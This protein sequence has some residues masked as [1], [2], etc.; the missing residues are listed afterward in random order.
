MPLGL[1]HLCHVLLVDIG[2]CDEF[3][4]DGIENRAAFRTHCMHIPAE[5]VPAPAE[6]VLAA[7]SAAVQLAVA[8]A[9]PSPPAASAHSSTA[10]T[11]VPGNTD[12]AGLPL[13]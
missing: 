1:L 6:P 8:A 9:A 3:Q 10:Y 4:L 5:L 13:R 12:A 11:A 2:I 7:S